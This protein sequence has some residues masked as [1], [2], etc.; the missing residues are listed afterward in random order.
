[1]NVVVFGANGK[2]GSLVVEKSRAAGHAVTVFVHDSGAQSH[3]GVRV[4]T[5]DAQSLD[6]VRKAIAGQD[7]VIDTIGGKT[8]YKDTQL[9]RTAARH[10][11]DAMRAQGVR[12][13]VVVSMMGIGDSRQQTPFWYKYLLMPTFLRGST[14]DKKAME[15]WVESSALDFVIARPPILSGDV[16][17]GSVRIITGSSKA[18][19]ITRGDL[20]QF[21]VDQ[22][23]GNQYLCQAVVVANR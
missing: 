18:H 8:P 15:A 21:I 10:I 2:T 12:R 7:A 6:A 23:T 13:L 9:E 11:V 3:P 20:A 22:L 16:A 1:M 17:T 19:R 14:R 4:V 5:G